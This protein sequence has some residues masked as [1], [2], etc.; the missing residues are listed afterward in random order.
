MA[1]RSRSVEL[2]KK[3]R[4]YLLCFDL[5]P[6]GL[7]SLCIHCLT[8]SFL[9]LNVL[10]ALCSAPRYLH[11]VTLCAAFH[12]FALLSAFLLSYNFRHFSVL[13]HTKTP[14]PPSPTSIHP[15][16]THLV[17]H[18]TERH[19]V[20][21]LPR[22]QVATPRR[23]RRVRI[24]QRHRRRHACADFHSSAHQCAGNVTPNKSYLRFQ[25]AICNILYFFLFHAFCSLK[26]LNSTLR[27]A[28]P[29]FKFAYNP[30]SGL[31]IGFD[32]L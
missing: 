15:I 28:Q 20:Q 21:P 32:T 14:L 8:F 1:V 6:Y 18:Y 30:F 13:A 24:T 4:A 25:P 17:I 9:F 23:S 11:F 16:F 2:E 3:L 10:F 19:P 26:L 7:Y 27:V 31:K 29:T 12:C 22:L 5:I